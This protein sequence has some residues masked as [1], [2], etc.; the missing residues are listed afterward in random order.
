MQNPARRL[1]ALAA[2]SLAAA[3]ASAQS[4]PTQPIR[5]IVPYPAGGGTDVVARTVASG[6][7][8]PLGQTIVV[9]N[10]GGAGGNLGAAEA[11][12]SEKDG[13]TLLLGSCTILAANKFLYR[14]SMPIDPITDLAPMAVSGVQPGPGLWKVSRD[15]R[16]LWVLGTLAPLPKRMEW[17]SQEVE[18]TIAQSQELLLPPMLSLDTGRGRFRTLFLLPA[19]FKAAKNP[20]GGTLQEVV[21]ADQYARWAVLKARAGT[22]INSQQPSTC[23]APRAFSGM[24]NARRRSDTKCTA[25]TAAQAS[26]AKFAAG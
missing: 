23:A 13:H 17:R 10:R 11:A 7:E 2:L 25:N 1:V 14:K 20:D 19:L 24:T 12:R 8:K 15:G 26:Q 5:W 22:P 3:T 18:D 9:D 21:P 6:L 4:W 16:T